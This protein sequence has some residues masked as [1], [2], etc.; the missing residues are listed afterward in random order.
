L[1]KAIDI[2]NIK[3][4]ELSRRTGISQQRLGQYVRKNY[5]ARQFAVCI[6]A[7]ALD[8]NPAWLAGYDVSME[9]PADDE[10]KQDGRKISD[11]DLKLAL[12]GTTEVSDD[13]L[14][15]IKKI[16][17]IHLELQKKGGKNE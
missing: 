5:E 13:L 7:K 3:K 16:A 1:Q 14:E 15:D 17:K 6:I 4:A 9:P 12:F 11:D 8:V 2:R 10:I